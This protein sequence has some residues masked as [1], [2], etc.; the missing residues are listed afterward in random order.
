[1]DV[2]KKINQTCTVSLI[3][4]VIE[5]IFG[6]ILKSGSEPS[7]VVIGTEGSQSLVRFIPAVPGIILYVLTA[8]TAFMSVSSFKAF[9]KGSIPKHFIFFTVWLVQAGAAFM[10]VIK[11]QTMELY[12]F[13][14]R[15][16]RIIQFA[17]ILFSFISCAA[18]RRMKISA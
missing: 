8:F 16:L 3:L 5:I 9:A 7:S 1:M 13:E 17:V 6:I 12:S 15:I 4:I 11:V 10:S 14:N 18:V 2:K